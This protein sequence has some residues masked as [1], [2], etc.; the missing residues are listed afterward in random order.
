[1]FSVFH[2]SAGYEGIMEK[3]GEEREP[4]KRVIYLISHSSLRESL[5][6]QREDGRL[7]KR[8]FESLN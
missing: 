5:L 4:I 2:D 6:K 3:A 8:Y 7:S 1:M